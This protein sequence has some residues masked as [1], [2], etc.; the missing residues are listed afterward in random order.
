MRWGVIIAVAFLAGCNQGDH[1]PISTAPTVRI[2]SP[3]GTGSPFKSGD[4]ILIQVDFSDDIE[5][6][7]MAVFVRNTMNNEFVY[8]RNLH[9]H[10][11]AYRWIEDTTFTTTVASVYQIT[12]IVTDHELQ[13]SEEKET[14]SVEPN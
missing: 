1:L 8:Q 5:L 11:N 13:R 6:H 14:F 10:G 12:A 9:K 2:M 3:L 7:E 4:R